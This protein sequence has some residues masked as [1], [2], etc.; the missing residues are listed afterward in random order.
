VS[1]SLQSQR[2]NPQESRGSKTPGSVALS[3]VINGEVA[4]T[5]RTGKRALDCRYAKIMQVMRA[6]EQRRRRRLGDQRGAFYTPLAIGIA[7]GQQRDITAEAAR[8]VI[9][10]SSLKRVDEFPGSQTLPGNL[11]PAR[12]CLAGSGLGKPLPR[13]AHDKL[14]EA[15]PRGPFVPRRSLGARGK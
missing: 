10:D 6:S 9:L 5:I 12:L 13:L 15:E 4:L 11:L 14:R 3:G 2:P 8:A 1:A 7:F